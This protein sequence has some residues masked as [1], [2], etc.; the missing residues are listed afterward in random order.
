MNGTGHHSQRV[1]RS[2]NN[3]VVGLASICLYYSY[4]SNNRLH[5]YEIIY[6]AAKLN[7]NTDWLPFVNGNGKMIKN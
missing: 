2:G 4:S 6:I 3:T 1:K 7:N 5:F